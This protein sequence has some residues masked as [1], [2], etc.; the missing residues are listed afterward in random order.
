[1]QKK[2]ERE[3]VRWELLP[4]ETIEEAV[5]ALMVGAK[6]HGDFD[7]Q[8]QDKEFFY[9]AL[10]RHIK[11]YQ[12]GVTMDKESG[13]NPLAHAMCNIIF[14]LWLEMNQEKKHENSIRHRLHANKEI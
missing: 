13:L 12:S 9:A 14:L 3:K 10:M 2:D 5:K 7:W 4:L 11:E 1:M 6:K 8:K